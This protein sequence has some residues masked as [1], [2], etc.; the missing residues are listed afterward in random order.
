MAVDGRERHKRQGVGPSLDSRAVC[1]AA[2]RCNL[3]LNQ[4]VRTK[5]QDGLHDLQKQGRDRLEIFVSTPTVK[6][7]A[8]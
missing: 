7:Y 1:M 2:G 5:H 3:G 6:E 8:N 4:L